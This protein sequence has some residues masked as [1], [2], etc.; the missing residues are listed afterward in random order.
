MP[1]KSFNSPEEAAFAMRE[2]T[3]VQKS[4][5]PK[6]GYLKVDPY[7]QTVENC[8]QNCDDQDLLPPR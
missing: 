3:G 6:V 1:D 8:A 7:N 4:D 5:E 2:M